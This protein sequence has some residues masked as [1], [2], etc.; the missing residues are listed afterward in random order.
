MYPRLR[1]TSSIPYFLVKSRLG[2]YL[3]NMPSA[4]THLWIEMVALGV[5]ILPLGYLLINGSI[6]PNEMASFLG[7]YLFSSFFLSPDLDLARSRASRRWGLSR[8]LWLPYSA[9]FRHRRLSHHLIWGPLTRILYLGGF[10]LA[11]TF[12]IASATNAKLSWPTWPRSF[13]VA[14]FCGLYL[15]NQIHIMVDHLWSRFRRRRHL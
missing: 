2:R 4:K 8:V 7:A 14:I 12:G 3:S 13:L 5:C 10:V 9:L 15:P 6:G 11:A 1:L